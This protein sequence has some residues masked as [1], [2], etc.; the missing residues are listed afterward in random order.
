LR[1]IFENKK[2]EEK[3][4]GVDLRYFCGDESIYSFE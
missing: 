1:D 2:L 3:T 4:V